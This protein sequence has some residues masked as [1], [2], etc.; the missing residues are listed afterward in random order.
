MKQT[1]Y[2]TYQSAFEHAYT[3]VFLCAIRK[4]VKL[5]KSKKRSER[6]TSTFYG[7]Y[8]P[9][10]KRCPPPPEGAHLKEELSHRITNRKNC[11]SHTQPPAERHKCFLLRNVKP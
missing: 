5:N 10:L 8:G 6:R 11:S 2:D 7:V 4:E 1:Q 3:R 9:L